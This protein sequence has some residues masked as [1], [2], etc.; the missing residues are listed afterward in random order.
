MVK[1]L[2]N[3]SSLRYLGILI[4]LV[5]WFLL[6]VLFFAHNEYLPYPQDALWRMVKLVVSGD[7][8]QDFLSTFQIFLTGFC[9]ATLI[10]VPLGIWLGFSKKVY[11]T[12][13][14]VLDFF[15]SIPVT[16]LFPIFILFFGIS[17]KTI[18]AMVTVACLFVIILNSAYGVLYVNKTYIKVA[19]SLGATWQQTVTEVI[20]YEALPFLLV[21]LRI[22]VS[23]GL[24]VV[25]VSEM[26]IGTRYGL[27]SRV[28]K[29]HE[30]YLIL[31]VYALTTLIGIIG[32]LL[33]Q[34][35][36]YFEKKVIHWKGH[37]KGRA[38]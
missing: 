15:R 6:K 30:T 19:K 18:T 20:F 1:N 31:D 3:T 32:Y 28:Y 2:F 10:G 35:L 36:L 12:F 34:G 17:P 21:G 16:A 27:G 33:N 13:E 4:F 25:V 29:A 11:A 26:F 37:E 8:T 14:V 23:F 38:I 5:I 22:A 24:I 9:L 7:L